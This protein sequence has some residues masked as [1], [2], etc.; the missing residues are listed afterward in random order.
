MRAISRLSRVLTVVLLATFVW[1]LF[2]RRR[3]HPVY[4]PSYEAP[5][6]LEQ[7]PSKK[8]AWTSD[9]Q[10]AAKDTV[11]T[12]ASAARHSGLA[13][14]WGVQRVRSRGT[15]TPQEQPD[16]DSGRV[17][18]EWLV[19]TAT[20][21]EVEEAL[22][23]SGVTFET[24]DPAMHGRETDLE[25]RV[26]AVGMHLDESGTGGVPSALARYS[27]TTSPRRLTNAFERVAAEAHTG[28]IVDASTARSV[29]IE[30]HHAVGTGVLA[31][32]EP[33]QARLAHGERA[34]AFFRAV[35]EAAERAEMAP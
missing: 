3:P 15:S 21:Q 10:A 7:E 32:L 33:S 13:L 2:R 27:G 31:L 29:L 22:A 25:E 23:V 16:L 9:L 28:F 34:R 1:K 35:H 26:E 5:Y 12:A 19:R 17:S 24:L 18:F 30:D 4:A 6:V 20:S 8:R 11:A 14:A